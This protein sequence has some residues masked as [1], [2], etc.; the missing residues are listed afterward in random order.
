[1]SRAA[2]AEASAGVKVAP[3]TGY[4]MSTDFPIKLTLDAPDGVKL[5]KEEQLAGKG[6][7][8]DATEFSEKQLA[9]TVKATADKPGTYE[10]KGWFRFGVCDKD[11]CHP[12]TQP[13]SIAV[14][15]N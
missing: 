9:F 10:V 11:S 2:G 13:I 6:K 5:A 8:G 4:H 7:Q 3:A 1:L 14:A 12:K 15:A